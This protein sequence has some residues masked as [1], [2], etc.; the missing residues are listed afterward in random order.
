MSLN[1]QSYLFQL[2][3]Y[4]KEDKT[5]GVVISDEN[6]RNY[7]LYLNKHKCETDCGSGPGGYWTRSKCARYN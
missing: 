1:K 4:F 5:V 2:M 6:H 7:Q 3:F